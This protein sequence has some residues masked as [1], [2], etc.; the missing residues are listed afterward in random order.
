[1]SLNAL[2]IEDEPAASRRLEKMIKEADPTMVIMGKLD[3]VSSSVKWF[4]EN[5]PPDLV[6]LDINLGDGVSF[7]IFDEIDLHCPVIF[8]TA[9]DEYA[10]RA[11]KLNSIDYLLKPIKQEELLFSIEKFKRQY[12]AGNPGMKENLM[13]MLEELK[14]PEDRWKKR[15]MVNFGE[16]IKAIDTQD[17]AYFMILEKNTFLVT[18]SNDSY[19]IG[20]SLE[21]LEEML[22]PAVFYRVN[23]KFIVSFPCI[24]NMWSYSRSRVKLQLEPLPPDDVIVSTDRSPGFKQWLDK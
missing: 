20:Y 5:P 10:L 22:D 3:S 19:G 24:K 17:I 2:I 13:A 1:M 18:L 7:N 4:R 14:K 11:F 21:Q 9:F 12:R 16:K 23:R 8:T 15:F 6:F